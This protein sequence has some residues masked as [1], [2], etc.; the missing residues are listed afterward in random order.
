MPDLNIGIARTTPLGISAGT[1]APVT[2]NPAGAALVMDWY[3]A[4][5]L[6]GYGWQVRAG[7]I[8]TPI[9]G[10]VPLADTAAEY[11]M[12]IANGGTLIPLSQII[13]IRLGTG[14]LHEYATK[15][16]I[17]A[18][19]A[20]TAFV[21][22]PLK[23]G[24]VAGGLLTARTQGT[25]NVTVTAEVATTT[26]RHWSFSQPIAMGAYNADCKWEPI[27][28][29][30]IQALTSA[31]RCLYTQIAATGTGPSYYAALNALAIPTALIGQ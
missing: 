5:I 16:V 7:T 10:P 3:A 23:T 24:S 8:T 25:G 6:N 2:L 30:V 27:R 21:P 4:Q 1:S 17:T 29:P 19:T 28:P 11:C 12:D 15:E 13:S 14:T 9:I 26:S 20:G 31:G 18:S 22:L